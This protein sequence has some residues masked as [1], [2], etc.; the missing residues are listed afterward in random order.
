MQLVALEGDVVQY[1]TTLPV[2]HRAPLESR[3]WVDQTHLCARN[4]GS[5]RIHDCAAQDCRGLG[6]RGLRPEHQDTCQN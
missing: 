3:Q 6:L 4:P 5:E 1:E 2:G